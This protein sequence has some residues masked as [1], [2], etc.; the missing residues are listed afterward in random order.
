MQ[1]TS[2]PVQYMAKPRLR[3]DQLALITATKAV[4]DKNNDMKAVI[5]N[6]I[7]YI[8]GNITTEEA[9]ALIKMR[10]ASE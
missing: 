4:S 3:I 6:R 7:S 1:S 5:R 9:A 2:I 10:E 8:R